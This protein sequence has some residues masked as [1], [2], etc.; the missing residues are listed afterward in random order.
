MSCIWSPPW[1][2]DDILSLPFFAIALNHYTTATNCFMWLSS[3]LFYLGPP[4]PKFPLIIRLVWCLTQSA[5]A[6]VTHLSLS[7]SAASPQKWAWC[8][9]KALAASCLPVP[10]IMNEGCLWHL[11]ES[12]FDIDYTSSSSAF[13]GW[14]WR[15][16]CTTLCNST[17]TEVKKQVSFL[18][19]VSDIIPDAS[20]SICYS[21]LKIIIEARS[22]LLW[23]LRQGL[24]CCWFFVV[25][26]L[27][28]FFLDM[29]SLYSPGCPGTH[30]EDQAGLKH[31]NPPASASRVLGSKVCATTPC[32]FFFLIYFMYMSTL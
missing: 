30:F 32:S 3:G 7:Q 17:A 10:A 1:W 11:L 22:L 8:S 25:V 6:S 15:Q 18:Y 16:L 4:F 14:H 27:F 12:S 26:G 2:H 19:H 29:V 31:R 28:D 23:L 9:S 13:L 5:C 21:L 20:A 24:F